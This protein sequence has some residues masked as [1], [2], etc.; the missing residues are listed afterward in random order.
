MLKNNDKSS[1]ILAEFAE[2]CTP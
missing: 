1:P 2:N